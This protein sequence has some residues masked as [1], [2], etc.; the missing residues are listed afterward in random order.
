MSRLK[1]LE[2]TLAEYGD[3]LAAAERAHAKDMMIGGER[4]PLVLGA[5][6]FVASLFFAHSGQVL[7]LDVLFYS[8][9]AQQYL[10]TIPE[11]IYVWLGLFGVVF[12]T[13]A[14][15]L[16]RNSLICYLAWFFSGCSMFFAIFAIWMRQ[17][18][19]PTDPGAGPSIGLVIGAICCAVVGLTWFFVV[20]RRSPLQEAVFKARR[21]REAK[22]SV[23]A[24]Q[25]RILESERLAKA[26]PL[27][28]DDRRSA[29]AQRRRAQSL[30]RIGTDIS[31]DF[32]EPSV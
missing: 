24:E 8:D 26:M 3:D 28:A 12:L 32:N 16:S 14:G 7:G 20:V 30:K 31:G 2:A 4:L 15:V 17:S 13:L 25:L 5:V 9:A 29:A 10:T 6:G 22:D 1:S 11:R 19:P 18:R 21:D 27:Q 23:A